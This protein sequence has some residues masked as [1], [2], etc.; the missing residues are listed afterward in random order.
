MVISFMK[1]ISLLFFYKY[2]ISLLVVACRLSLLSHGCAVSASPR[3]N[4]WRPVEQI[5][6]VQS[7][8]CNHMSS[9][10]R[11][12]KSGSGWLS[13]TLSHTAAII[14]VCIHAICTSSCA[15]DCL[16][17]NCRPAILTSWSIS[18]HFLLLFYTIT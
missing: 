13:S 9:P 4:K 14:R 15:K 18:R 7:W 3:I 5:V 16:T 1:K 12:H 6:G 17:S 2:F 8:S 11:N 10:E